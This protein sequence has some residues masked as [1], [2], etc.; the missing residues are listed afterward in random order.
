M[1]RLPTERLGERAM[2][3]AF[4]YFFQMLYPFRAV[5]RR[6]CPVAA[7]AGGCMLVRRDAYD[8]IG[9][10]DAI[11]SAIID[12]CALAKALKAVGPIW[13]G[14]S[15]KV[16]SLRGYPGFAPLREMVTRSA[17][18]ELRFSPWRLAVAVTGMILV[19]VLPPLLVLFARGWPQ[20]LGGL[21]FIAMALSFQPTLRLYRLNP[22]WALALPGIAALYTSLTLQSALEFH[23]GRG[24]LWKG[25]AQAHTGAH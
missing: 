8:K 21:A 1:V 25:R 24:G 19:F 11:R 14:L 7:G 18:A 5:A 22:L 17:Y 3:P 10:M 2:L 20:A 4:V 9:G 16:R 15:T 6:D 13:L 12:D 23:Q